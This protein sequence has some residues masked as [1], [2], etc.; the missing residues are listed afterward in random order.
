[1]L[2]THLHL[3]PRLKVSGAIPVL[4]LHAFMVC[5]GTTLL[6]VLL[7][8]HNLSHKKN[9]NKPVKE[10]NTKNERA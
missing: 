7:L 1:M 4:L 2:T 6:H 9:E 8:T 5:T 3:V 10:H